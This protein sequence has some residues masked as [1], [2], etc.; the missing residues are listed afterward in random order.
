MSKKKKKDVLFITV[1]VL[2]TEKYAVCPDC[3]S[4]VNCGTIG[5]TNLEKRHRRKKVF[6]AAQEKWDKEMKIRKD[7]SI[8]NF[9]K[10]KATIIV[11][12]MVNSPA[13][14]YSYKLPLQSEPHVSSNAFITDMQGKTVSSMS[15]SASGPIFNCFI[16]MLQELVKDLPASVPEASAFDKLVV[17][18]GS[19]KEFDD[20]TLDAEELWEAILNI[21]LKSMLGWR[22]E[23]N[24]DD[25]IYCGKW[26]LDSLV[27]F[28]TYFVEEQGMSE[29]LFKGKL[30]NLV[31]ALKTRWIEVKYY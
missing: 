17:F 20:P 4:H 31:T 19:P 30:T 25:I 27:N 8:L 12:S 22:I 28:A 9:L 21:V 29:G 7:R 16:K 6:K 14:V 24:M 10:P 1:P 26:G 15:Q 13:P 18:G 23:E 3:D 2:D 5:L 11:P